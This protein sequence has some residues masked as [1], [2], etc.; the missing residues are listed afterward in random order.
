MFAMRGLKSYITLVDKRKQHL[1][2]SHLSGDQLA[3]C[4][5]QT[6]LKCLSL[7]PSTPFDQNITH[8]WSTRGNSI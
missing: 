5:N 8:T 1:I 2:V 6:Q 4:S 3:T 7:S